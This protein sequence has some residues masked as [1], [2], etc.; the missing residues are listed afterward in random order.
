MAR[1]PRFVP[2]SAMDY[3]AARTPLPPGAALRLDA[4]YRLR[5][6]PLVSPRHPDVIARAAGEDYEM[7]R[8]GELVSLVAPLDMD[9]IEA[10]P[11]W[12]AMERELREGSL[13]ARIAWDIASRRRGRMHATICGALDLSALPEGW[14]GR[15]AALGPIEARIGGP[16]SGNINVGRLYLKLYPRITGGANA[17]HAVQE[18]LGRRPGRL[19]VAGMHNLT[20]HLD[21][22]ETSWLA[23]WLRRWEN[24]EVTRLKLTELWLLGSRDD[25][26]LDSRIVERVPLE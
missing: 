7:G 26:V 16:F 13:A 14:R 19:F 2:D 20:D 8:H 15:L 18:A 4:S 6:L 10:S 17:F 5:H 21:V 24:G 1:Q 11:V 3:A 12:Q 25:L 22:E 23:A 9:A